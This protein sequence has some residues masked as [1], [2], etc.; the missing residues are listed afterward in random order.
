MAVD[1]KMVTRAIA[2]FDI[3]WIQALAGHDFGQGQPKV[4]SSVH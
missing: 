2:S 1:Y 3:G 4:S